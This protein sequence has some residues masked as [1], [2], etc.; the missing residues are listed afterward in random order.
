MSSKRIWSKIRISI[1]ALVLI[2]L[3]SGLSS[4]AVYADDLQPRTV[5]VGSSYAS[6]VTD[7]T[8]TFRMVTPSNVGS[9]AFEYCSNSPLF[10][11][12]CV[13]PSG[14]DVDAFILGD[15]TGITD[16]SKNAVE[17]TTSRAVLSRT[18]NAQP[19]QDLEYELENITNPDGS[20]ATV[21]VRISMYASNDGTG[22]AFDTGA[23]AFVIEEPFD[24][25]AYVP[26]YLTFCVGV[27]VAV[28]CSSA[29]GFLSEFG[30]FSAAST[31]TATTQMSASS[32]DGD[33]YVIYVNGQTMT[34]GNNVISPLLVR[35]AATPGVS[36]FGLNL[37]QNTS[38]S[39]GA[40]PQQGPVGSGSA[41]GDYS[42]PNQ[43]TFVNGDVVAGATKSSGFTRYTVS[44]IVNVSNNQAP[45]VY[46]TS[47]QYTALATF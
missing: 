37:R 42:F 7:H 13:A 12:P 41:I 44:Y 26:P 30:E 35:S 22:S 15:Q 38:P 21:F 1:A 17:T 28:D 29:T 40:N 24:V 19:S 6:E 5:R 36:Q 8:F 43:F 27:S 47:L 45:G 34:S 39:V 23:V 14:L 25:D 16:F 10:T 18:I 3:P 32:N 2:S 20:V 31:I 33:G 46:A 11:E 9:I 4:R